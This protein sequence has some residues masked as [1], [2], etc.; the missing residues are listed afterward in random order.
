M[1]DNVFRFEFRLLGEM[2][3]EMLDPGIS[4]SLKDVSKSY[5]SGKSKQ[6][7]LTNFNMTVPKGTM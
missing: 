2:D 4:L 5:G 1:Q 7:V 6:Q 3:D